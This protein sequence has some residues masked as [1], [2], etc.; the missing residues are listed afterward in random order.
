MLTLVEPSL[1]ELVPHMLKEE[2]ITCPVSHHFGPN[3]YVRAVFI[4]AGT[5]ALGHAHRSEHLTNLVRGKMAVYTGA[6][7][8]VLKEGPD[9]FLSPA[10]RKLVYTLE[11]CL[12]QNI[13][14]TPETD[15]ETLENTLVDKSNQWTDQQIV[16][17][18]IQRLEHVAEVL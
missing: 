15:I 12:V 6:G 2:Q 9:M 11:D 10:G 3:V 16:D 8:P 7:E 14:S 4:P 18:Q 1:D 13:Y 5:I 17:G